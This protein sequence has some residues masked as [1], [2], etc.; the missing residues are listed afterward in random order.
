MCA[1]PLLR[2]SSPCHNPARARPPGEQDTD[3]NDAGGGGED[4]LEAAIAAEHAKFQ[5]RQ[6][7]YQ[8][9]VR[10]RR[11]WSAAP[12]RSP[13][14]TEIKRRVSLDTN[15]KVQFAGAFACV[16]RHCAAHRRRPLPGAVSAPRRRHRPLQGTSL[17]SLALLPGLAVG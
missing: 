1:W 12:L 7:A 3:Q 15:A 6:A 10:S 4:P 17:H 11:D 16:C 14:P 5:E 8:A 9:D 2:L 13:A